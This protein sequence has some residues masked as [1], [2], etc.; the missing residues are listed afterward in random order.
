MGSE[1]EKGEFRLVVPPGTYELR[2]YGTYLAPKEEKL[3]VPAGTREIEVTLTAPARKFAL[4]MGHRAPELRGIAAWKNGPP[5]KLADLRGKCVILEFWNHW[6]YPCLERMPQT[7][8]LYEEYGKQGLVVIGVHVDFQDFSPVESVAKLDVNLVDTRKKLWKGRDLPFPVALT[9]HVKEIEA[10]AADD[11]GIRSYP[12]MLLID[13]RG[14]LV[15]IMHP[16]RPEGVALLQKTLDERPARQASAA[17]PASALAKAST[18][19]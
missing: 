12:T 4:L 6:C 9:R 18:G 11:Y 19:K 17:I 13:R 15:D 2:G 5:L 7:I 3:T 1:S 8:K 14:N 10:A 16:G